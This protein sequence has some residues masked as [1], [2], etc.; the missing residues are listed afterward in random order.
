MEILSWNIQAAKG[1]DEVISTERIANDIKQF[2]DAD[3]ICLQEVMCTPA[4]NQV[5][6]FT[7]LFNGYTP[8][9][10]AAI[11]RLYP[12][13]RLQFGN[14]I[15]TRL[16]LL[17]IFL[18]KL[19]QPAEPDCKYMPRQAVEVVVQADDELLRVT[20]LHLEYFAA[21][22]RAAQVNY[23]VNHHAECLDRFRH[24]SPEPGQ[25]QFEPLAQTSRNIYCGDFNLTVDSPDYRTMV[26]EGNNDGLVDCW[27][28]VHQQASHDPTCGIYDRVQWEEGP[29]CRDFFFASPDVA[30][31]LKEFSVN[32]K[33]AASDHQPFKIALA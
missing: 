19:P 32:Q 20:T 28:Q 15:L 26:Q 12:G 24:P 11:D 17:Q 23:L 3:V 8:V 13:G 31:S 9:F 2:A 22:Q 7:A 5:A 25:E 29:H 14:M 6:E 18:H 16:P 30:P 1:V 33:T 21:G 10:G 27:R 4:S